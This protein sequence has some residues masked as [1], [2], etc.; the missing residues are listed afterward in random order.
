MQDGALPRVG[1]HP[2][3]AAAIALG[4]R[5]DGSACP[6]TA[7]SAARS[8]LQSTAGREGACSF[9]QLHALVPRRSLGQNFMLDDGVLAGIVAAAGVQPGDLVLEIGPGEAVPGR[10]AIGLLVGS[11]GLVVVV[12]VVVVGVIVG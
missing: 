9:C 1:R 8:N 2:A 5:N 4:V 12:V 11:G 3:T 6:A 10:F 7:C